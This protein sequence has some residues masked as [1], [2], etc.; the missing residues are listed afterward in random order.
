MVSS[1]FL[2]LVCLCLFLLEN[3]NC[4]YFFYI[5][6]CLFILEKFVSSRE[7]YLCLF[8]L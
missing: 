4:V 5:N 6:L 7:V 1:M 2:L 8:L 3:F